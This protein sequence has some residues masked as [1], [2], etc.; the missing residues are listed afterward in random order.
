MSKDRPK[1][2]Q[3]DYNNFKRTRYFHGMLLTDRDFREEQIYHNEK[4]KLLN[5]MLHGWGVVCG[6]GIKAPDPKS[7]KI[8][9]TPGMALD[10]A[11]NEIVVCEEYEID[12]KKQLLCPDTPVGD[13]D[14]CAEKDRG[15]KGKYYIGIKY[16]EV[17]TDPVPVYA[18]GG[19]CE[20]KVCDYSRTNEGFCVKLFDEAA[21]PSQPAQCSSGKSLAGQIYTDCRK[22]K[23]NGEIDY[24]GKCVEEKAKA[25]RKD[26]CGSTACCPDCCP[27]EHY[28]ILGSVQYNENDKKYELNLNE[29]RQYVISVPYVK[30]LFSSFFSG[31]ENILKDVVDEFRGV[32]VPDVNLIVNNP[33]AAICWISEQLLMRESKAEEHADSKEVKD[34]T[35]ESATEKLKA[36]GYEPVNTVTLTEANKRELYRLSSRVRELEESDAVEIVVDKKNKPQFYIPAR[37]KVAV[38]AFKRDLDG[39][40]KVIAELRTEIE[41]LK[42]KK[43]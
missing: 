20:E 3:C 25:F 4:R 9:V 16:N 12:L 24:P 29:G 17:P 43:K 14:P 38:K 28:L 7:P 26:F 34:M 31:A 11:G 39:N 18:P 37:E 6:L 13:E 15:R 40:M 23:E 8:V 42:K 27:T 32:D 1:D 30:Y 35:L 33:A 36:R 22:E 10:C 19:G 41:K 2:R 5:R 21:Y